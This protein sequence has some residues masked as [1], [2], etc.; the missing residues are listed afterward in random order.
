M[1]RSAIGNGITIFR[2]LHTVA[3]SLQVVSR[4]D[5]ITLL[6]LHSNKLQQYHGT[7]PQQE[8]IQHGEQDETQEGTKEKKGK[9][10]T[11]NR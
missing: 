10:R 7:T 9:C 11:T 1:R 8:E 4:T 2:H 6:Q 3:K 5:A